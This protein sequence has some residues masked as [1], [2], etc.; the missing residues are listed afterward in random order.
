LIRHL[1]GAAVTSML[2]CLPP[3]D[4]HTGTTDHTI[5]DLLTTPREPELHAEPHQN[6]HPSGEDSPPSLEVSNSVI[7]LYDPPGTLHRVNCRSYR[8]T[9]IPS[10]ATLLAATMVTL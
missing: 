2:R 7:Q 5:D 3:Q 4:V 6:L 10:L 1:H 9:Y 8:R